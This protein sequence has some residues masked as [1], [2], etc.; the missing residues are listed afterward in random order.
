MKINKLM[1][2]AL[3]CIAV[4]A[5]QAQNTLADSAEDGVKKMAAK[6]LKP[7]K[8]QVDSVSYLIGINFGS[9]IKGYNFGDV[10][11]SEMEKGIKDFVNAKGNTMDPSFT[12]QFKIDPNLMNDL[13]NNYLAKMA[14]Y[15]S[16]VNREKE[17][18]YLEANKKKAEVLETPSGLQY[19]IVAPGNDVHPSLLDTVLVR[20]R[21]TLLDGSV[22]DEV[23]ADNDPVEM[24]LNRVIAGWQEGLQLIGEG[25]SIKLFV[26][27]ALG[28]GERGSNGIEPNATLLFDVDLVEVHPYVAEAEEEE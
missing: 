12:D 21:G 20:Y 24:T 23:P 4:V 16:A 8:A 25:G 2:A 1:A 15:T 22:F 9:F 19:Q 5:C 6:D 13:F 3:M 18:K 26:P 27:S 14:E 17:E 7:S 28:Y 11:F 10:N